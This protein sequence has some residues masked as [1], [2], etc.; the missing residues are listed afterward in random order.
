[1]ERIYVRGGA[2]LTGSIQVGG[3]K[4][5]TLALMAACLLV[6]GKTTLRGVPDIRDVESMADIL[7]ALGADVRFS[8]TGDLEIDAAGFRR[9]SISQELTGQLR[10]SFYV[11]GP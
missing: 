10:A 5:A 11:L 1:M 6:D 9:T 2:P 3:S 8:P 4:N 7:Q